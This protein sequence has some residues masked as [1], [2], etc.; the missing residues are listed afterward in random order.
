MPWDSREGHDL[1]ASSLDGKWAFIPQLHNQDIFT[2]I[3]EWRGMG[4]KV[5]LQEVKWAE[6][7]GDVYGR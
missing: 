4:S 1:Q 5:G 3:S 6:H 2:V 7:M